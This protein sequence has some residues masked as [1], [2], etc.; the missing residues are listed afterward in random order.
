MNTVVTAPDKS[1]AIM[2]GGGAGNY[3]APSHRLRLL[4]APQLSPFPGPG[5]LVDVTVGRGRRVGF[6]GAETPG[7]R[8]SP[9]PGP[10]KGFRAFLPCRAAQR[11][12]EASWLLAALADPKRGF[13][14]V[15]GGG[16]EAGVLRQLVRQHRPGLR[17]LRPAAVAARSRRP[18]RPGQ[19]GPRP[20]H[21][22]ARRRLQRRAE[23]QN[24]APP[25]A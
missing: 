19:R 20:D 2:K 8:R 16:A 6:C 3:P 1:A 13:D 9:H 12:P 25:K 15:A 14:T 18:Y 17:P 4:D 23:P 7:M 11:R 24:T 10:A 5:D 21:V 22:R